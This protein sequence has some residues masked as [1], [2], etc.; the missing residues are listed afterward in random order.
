M[1]NERNTF[2]IKLAE[3]Y[4]IDIICIIQ[5]EDLIIIKS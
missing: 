2:V 4:L 3:D 1:Y 5:N